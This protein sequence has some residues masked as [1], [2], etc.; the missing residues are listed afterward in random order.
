MSIQSVSAPSSITNTTKA[1]AQEAAET[2]V[3]TVQ[4][5][6]HGDRQAQRLVAKRAA[7]SHAE[8]KTAVPD[9][10]TVNSQGQHVGKIV[11]TAA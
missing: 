8:P 5:A 9:A 2:K 7:A 6:S 1:A 3:Q 10:P 4:E 11:N